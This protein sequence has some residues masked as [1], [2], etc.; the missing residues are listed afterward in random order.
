MT[1]GSLVQYDDAVRSLPNGRKRKVRES[2]DEDD[3]EEVQASRGKDALR[4][5]RAEILEL[6]IQK[7]MVEK[8]A[9]EKKQRK[10]EQEV[11]TDFGIHFQRH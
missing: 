7:D 11:S 5:L 2:E 3:L 4:R 1:S 10:E 6:A 8:K 9:R